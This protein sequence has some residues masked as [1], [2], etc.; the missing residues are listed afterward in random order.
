MTL[1]LQQA[2]M[3]QEF[4]RLVFSGAAAPRLGE[5]ALRAKWVINDIDVRRTWVLIGD[6]TMKLR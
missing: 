3:N 2:V 1:P 6:P 5:A 4:Y